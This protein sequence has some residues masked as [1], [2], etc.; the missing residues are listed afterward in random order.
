MEGG[1]GGVGGDGEGDC[2]G[3]LVGVFLGETGEGGYTV[4]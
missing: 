1:E 2:W 3:L 4:A